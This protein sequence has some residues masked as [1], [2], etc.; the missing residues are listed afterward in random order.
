MKKNIF[1][2]V[3]ALMMLFAAFT[4]TSCE[5]NEVVDDNVVEVAFNIHNP[6]S[7]GGLKSGGE[8]PICDDGAVPAYVI[9][10]LD[11]KDPLKVPVLASYDVT[12]TQTIKFNLG[13]AD[14][15]VFLIVGFEVYDAGDNL[16]WVSPLAGSIYSSLLE[17]PLDLEFIVH[18]FKK[19]Q[20]DIDV[21]CWVPAEYDNFGYS[22][23][24][25]H[26][27]KV[28]EVC[29]FGD[30]CTKFYEQWGAAAHD[31]PAKFSVTIK[32]AQDNLVTVIEEGSNSN[33]GWNE[34]DAPLCVKYMDD[35]EDSN[36]D[37]VATISL[38]TPEGEIEI[39]KVD[40][41]GGIL[42]GAGEDNV[43]DFLV[44]GSDC[45]FQGEHDALYALPWMP[46]PAQVDLVLLDPVDAYFE[47][48]LENVYGTYSHPDLQASTV[49][50]A[51]CGNAEL[52]I[53]QEGTSSFFFFSWET[54][55]HYTAN[56][57]PYYNIPTTALQIYQDIT[58][59]QWS[60]LNYMANEVF[61]MATAANKM[62]I[63]EA[64]WWILDYSAGVS[65]T[66]A[67][68]AAANDDYIAPIGG[69]IIVL[70]DPFQR[71]RDWS[72]WIPCPIEEQGNYQLL[73]V[74]VDP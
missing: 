5:K 24:D 72:T 22:W 11:G 39:G 12:M 26:K 52:G 55:W 36:E 63:Q 70:L 49:L 51:W 38:I 4:F 71:T 33:A 25:F 64:I 53:A 48:Q 9:I 19:A 67:T 31:F 57:Y 65:N 54:T 44:G 29:F 18:K 69:N 61:P 20:I 60:M 59:E 47:L 21:V 28:Y 42:A 14:S 1:S 27:Y 2:G 32:D 68:E 73:I 34:I 37:F 58:T 40:I 46:L 30:V 17:N 74:K 15:E 13:Q 3:I 7:E 10:T 8:L 35:V 56:V 50:G 23:L 41:I 66:Y 16:I 62:D 45:M 6:A 43:F